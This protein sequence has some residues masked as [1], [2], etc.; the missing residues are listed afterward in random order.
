MKAARSAETPPPVQHGKQSVAGTSA[1]GKYQNF[2]VRKRIVK[3][4]KKGDQFFLFLF[5]VNEVGN[6]LLVN[7][8][9]N[10]NRIRLESEKS[11]DGV[12]V[13]NGGG[14]GD[15]LK[16][17]SRSSFQSFKQ[18]GQVLAPVLI[19]NGVDFINDDHT[20][21]GD[22]LPEIGI[23]APQDHVEGFRCGDHEVRIAAP[24]SF[25]VPGADTET[26]PQARGDNGIQ[27][28]FQ[29][30][31]QCPGGDNV[32]DA[33]G[34]FGEKNPFKTG[35]QDG[36]RFTGTGCRLQDQVLALKDRINGLKLRRKESG[37][38]AVKCPIGV[39]QSE[40]R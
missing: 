22:K 23:L 16:P 17:F 32:E 12:H 1:V 8:L 10:A 11:D 28:A 33:I 30:K 15:F 14:K 4:V 27:T 2:P 26:E 3:V 29:V 36:L 6:N 13:G 40:E 19:H 20:H 31:R 34:A 24:G 7:V 35:G 38:G 9:C 39:G 21:L 37:K 18:Q 5:E 25:N